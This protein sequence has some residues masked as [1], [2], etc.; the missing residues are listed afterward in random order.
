VAGRGEAVGVRPRTRADRAAAERATEREVGVVAAV[1]EA[2]SDRRPPTASA[3]RTRPSSTTWRTRDPGSAR[4]QPRSW[5][6]SWRR[7][8]PNPRA[9]RMGTNGSPLDEDRRASRT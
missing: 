1:L 4:R 5:C 8:S 2:G 6:G 9:E 7:G 3:C